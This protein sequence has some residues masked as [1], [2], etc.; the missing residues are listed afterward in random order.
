[1]SYRLVPAKPSG[2]EIPAGGWATI[3][4]NAFHPAVP[5]GKPGGMFSPLPNNDHPG[6]PYAP[7][8][9]PNE[10]QVFKAGQAQ[11][12]PT[13]GLRLT[14]Q[15]QE[16]VG[17]V[18]GAGSPINYVSGCVTTQP[19]LPL[20]GTVG[21][22]Q[23]GFLWMPTPGVITVIESRM[24]LPTSRGSDCGRWWSSPKGATEI[25][26]PEATEYCNPSGT[27]M[28]MGW[29]DHLTN[30]NYGASAYNVV[31]QSDGLPH[32]YTTCYDG[33]ERLVSLYLDA[34]VIPDPQPLIT[35]EWP[36]G[37]P[38]GW[39]P[40]LM[41]LIFSYALRDVYGQGPTFLGSDY[42]DVDHVAIYQN[43][44]GAGVG[45]SGGGVAPGTAIQWP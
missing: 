28:G 3:L 26:D 22:D 6:A 10:V 40:A 45:V 12:K 32:L 24:R 25:D 37:F 29:I 8:F 7:G 30:A 21:F 20:G 16:G 17:G 4:A 38:T 34:D 23:T 42:W 9:N 44:D 11:V 43:A 2:V 18:N 27:C 35:Y 33:I 13:G 1:M 36:A 14:A 19:L 41:Y 39:D 31:A 5:L 15:Y